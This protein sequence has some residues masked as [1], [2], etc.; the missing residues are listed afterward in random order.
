MAK[1][2]NRENK[3]REIERQMKVGNATRI[4]AREMLQMAKSQ[5][6]QCHIISCSDTRR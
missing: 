1:R 3:E 2:M 4:T 6:I 5:I